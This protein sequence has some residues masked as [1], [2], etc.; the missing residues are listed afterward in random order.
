MIDAISMYA[1]QTS[2]TKKTRFVR[3]IMLSDNECSWGIMH[4]CKQRKKNSR[5]HVHFNE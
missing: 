3:A 5:S 4:A 1:S 2:H